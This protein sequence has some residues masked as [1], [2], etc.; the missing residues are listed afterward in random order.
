MELSAPSD[1]GPT[2][3]VFNDVSTV[4]TWSTVDSLLDWAIPEQ[5]HE[6][7]CVHSRG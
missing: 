3:W 2:Q 1:T 4:P 7:E 5:I 6:E